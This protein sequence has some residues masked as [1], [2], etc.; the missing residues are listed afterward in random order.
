M[1]HASSRSMS[2]ATIASG[3]RGRASATNIPQKSAHPSWSSA[4][5]PKSPAAP[6]VKLHHSNRAAVICTGTSATAHQI[7]ANTIPAR[8]RADGGRQNQSTPAAAAG[9]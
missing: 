7:V 8:A 2:G 6:G 1:S 4:G 9:R 3:T 5:M